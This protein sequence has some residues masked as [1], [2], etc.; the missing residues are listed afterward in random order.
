[1]SAKA[2]I[3]RLGLLF[4]V[5]GGL[6]AGG[7]A[8][9]RYFF[10]RKGAD[11]LVKDGQAA[12]ARGEEALSAG[13]G[14]A[15]DAHFDEADLLA[16]KALEDIEVR[17][18]NLEDP[19][20][21]RDERLWRLAGEAYWLRARALRDRAYAQALKANK[22][23]AVSTDSSTGEKFRSLHVITDVDAKKEAYDCLC[24]AARH[25]TGSREV[26]KEAL[27]AEIQFASPDWSWDRV[28]FLARSILLLDPTD[29]R[30]HFLLAQYDFEQFQ[31]NPA[32][33]PAV[34]TPPDQRSR[35]RVLRAR[36]HLPRAE[37][38]KDLKDVPWRTLYL[39][40]RIHEWLINDY[41]RTREHEKADGEARALRRLLLDKAW[42]ALKRAERGAGRGRM[43]SWDME[44]VFGLH[45]M[46]LDQ[47][48]ADRPRPEGALDLNRASDVLN[49]VLAFC[50]KA[51]KEGNNRERLKVAVDTAVTAACRAQP[52]LSPKR[53]GEWQKCVDEVEALAHQAADKGLGT[54]AMYLQLAGL[55]HYDAHRAAGRGL[56]AQ[57]AQLDK[58]ALAWI[59]EGLK[60]GR[61][62][63]VPPADLDDLHAAAALAKAAGPGNTAAVQTHLNAL[64][65][66][67]KPGAVAVVA[68]LEGTALQREG[69]LD[70]ARQKLEEVLRLPSTGLDTQAHAL[71]AD[72][73]LALGRWDQ[74][75]FHLQHLETTFN[76]LDRLPDA[77]R[78]WF[79]RFQPDRD[80]VRS[81][82]VR[83]HLRTAM[84]RSVRFQRDRPGEPVPPSLVQ[85]HEE[86]VQKLLKRMKPGTAPER[87]ARQ[88]LVLYEADTGRLDQAK[89]DLAAL[90]KNYPDS[91]EVL[92]LEIELVTWPFLS[93][94]RIRPVP[95]DPDPRAVKE[96]DGLILGFIKDHPRHPT[97]RLVYAAW[98]A[99][100]RRADKAVAYLQDAATFPGPRDDRYKRVLAEALLRAGQPTEGL[101]LLEHLPR[102]PEVDALLIRAAATP[103]DRK[104]AVDQ[105]A[106]RYENDGQIRCWKGDLAFGERQYADAARHYLRAL[107]LTRTRAPAQAG[108]RQALFALADTDPRKARELTL[109]MLKDYPE[110]PALLLA[111]AYAALLLD[112]VGH[113]GQAWGQDR[114]MASALN[115]WEKTLAADSSDRTTG[116]LTRA[117]FWIR[118]NRP[119]LAGAEVRRV[120]SHHARN[121]RALTLAV[122]LAVEAKDPH[123]L[124][125]A[126]KQVAVL[127]ELRPGAPEPLWLQARV[128]EARRQFPEAVKTLET[129]LARHPAYAAAYALLVNLLEAQ[130]E[131]DRARAWAAKWR[132]ALPDD[133]LAAQ[134]EVRQLAAA[135]QLADAR[136]AADRFLQRE[137][138]RA[139]K[140][141]ADMKFPTGTDVKE[142][143]GRRRDDV[144]A[145]RRE[146]R[147]QMARGFLQAGALAEA[148]ARLRELL[149][150]EPD[151]ELPQLLL[152]QVYWLRHEWQKAADLYTRFL[153]KHQGHFEA[154]NNLAWVLA[155]HLDQPKR[156]LDIAQKL[157]KNRFTDKDMAVDRLPPA[158]L[159]T[160]GVIYRKL[161]IIPRK[162]DK[163]DVYPTMRDLFEAACRRYPRDPRMC[164]YLGLAY[165]G[166]EDRVKAD[167]ALAT[168][169]DLAGPHAIGPLSPAQRQQVREEVR[170]ALAKL[171]DQ[172]P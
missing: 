39:L 122:G 137:V 118:A 127:K 156:A 20:G 145:T 148:E 77:E 165:A 47:V 115:A 167:R 114:T 97:G 30:A 171:K 138:E 103:E 159:D 19:A 40:A 63:G 55:L 157:R 65:Q 135:G 139:E 123:L 136:K 14:E 143:A 16:R 81:R 126:R 64:R 66:S 4:L 51:A 67:K 78:A 10:S 53:P 42:G 7:Y 170:R 119:D 149:D 117:A 92:R 130:G 9:Y 158:F 140:R 61:A 134:A 132:K 49:A 172:V 37:D 5:A 107:E 50:G 102:D 3:A 84:Q 151:L 128:E 69:K 91:I 96:A 160:L 57:Q 15:A 124:D 166:L 95:R 43:S 168:A 83:A 146:V 68:F 152:G 76:H 27:R 100:T 38:P 29:A 153:K 23:L 162:V 109:T 44:G 36:D 72:L 169:L 62:A 98:L 141:A 21:D 105:A 90:K 86:A 41:T 1:M 17:G 34:P 13:R 163:P 56:K 18:G 85:G 59:E 2:N 112:E 104:K 121:E 161:G 71:L 89:K 108:L 12:Y 131:K 116:P 31:P 32:G 142:A 45:L 101:K 113:P 155:A 87:A 58:Q 22:P 129:L 46:A 150:Q 144:D 110:E 94:A 164:L 54:P 73:N 52:Y 24:Q 80:T 25:L 99:V 111:F 11:E 6:G 33:G 26:L 147:L 106:A 28:G 35:E 70:R 79:L 8:G 154:G 88:A 48:L 125:E 60:V 74:A 120:L 93:Q 82:L 133:V 75:L